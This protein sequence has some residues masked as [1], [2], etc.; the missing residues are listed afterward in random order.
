M[1][2]NM[3]KKLLGCILVGT[4]AMGTMTGCGNAQEDNKN[5]QN[6]A[7]PSKED[8]K[9]ETESSAKEEQ[10]VTVSYPIETEEEI[11]LTVYNVL[12]EAAAITANYTNMAETPHWKAWQEQTG[13]KL[14]LVTASDFSLLVSSGDIPD[15]IM[16][17]QD[18]YPGGAE[19]AIAENVYIPLNDYVDY[20]PDYMKYYNEDA[21][22]RGTC[23]SSQGDIFCLSTCMFDDATRMS[24]GLIAREDWLEDLG[25]DKPTTPDQFYNMLK[26]FKE[27]KGAEV[28]FSTTIGHL[29]DN[30]V[31]EGVLTDG[32][33]LPRADFY[34]EDGLMHY[35][36]AEQEYKAVLEWLHKLYDEGL[37]DPNY[38][39]LDDATVK[40]NIESG[41]SGATSAAAGSGLG[42]YIRDMAEVDP[43]Y[44]LCG[45]P[46]LASAEGERSRGG[47][48]GAKVAATGSFV[49]TACEYPEIAVQF[50]NYAYTEEG[51]MLMN[52]GIEGE[53]Y[54]M[55]DGEAIYTDLI[56]NN[57]DGWSM[58][59]ALAAYTQGWFPIGGMIQDGGYANQYFG[60][61]QQQEAIATWADND[62]AAYDLPVLSVAGEDADEFAKISNEINTYVSEMFVKYV[63]GTKSLDT[64][65]SE[66]LA[67][68]KTLN[69]DRYIELYQKTYDAFMLK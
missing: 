54:T 30:L 66:Y 14:E 28:P 19:A 51:H 65:E 44:N 29:K 8:A 34:V 25:L 43:E 21:E 53:S 63:N 33:G 62:G 67:T 60:L 32:F 10:P 31:H 26:L 57:P 56:T 37:L 48:Y 20:M 68:L 36:Y 16:V 15:I 39:T 3:L 23:T 46:S 52:F 7:T 35:G 42:T 5:T 6:T 49:T 18:M 13:V 64:F 55:V 45:L 24:F 4:L 41:R 59:Q 50:L 1:K 58:Q 69:V 2:K 61:P 22:L 40:A 9:T 11:T 47:R 27:E 17:F 38:A 12:G